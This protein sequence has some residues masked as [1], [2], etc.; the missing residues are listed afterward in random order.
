MALF[1]Y[2]GI[3]QSTLPHAIY[4]ATA[5]TSPPKISHAYLIMKAPPTLPVLYTKRGETLRGGKCADKRYSSYI[6]R[7][8]I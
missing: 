2:T 6:V 3:V 5:N 1:T 8:Y 7:E 4:L